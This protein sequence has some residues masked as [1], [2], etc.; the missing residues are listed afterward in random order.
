[1][2]AALLRA[3][4]SKFY[5]ALVDGHTPWDSTSCSLAV[6]EDKSDPR[7]FRMAT[8]DQIDRYVVEGRIRAKRTPSFM[9]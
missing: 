1:M 8:E 7:G 4:T 9:L 6:G 2:R 3:L 5:L